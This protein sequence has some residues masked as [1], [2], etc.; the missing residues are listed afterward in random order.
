MMVQCFKLLI[1]IAILEGVSAKGSLIDSKSNNPLRPVLK[2]RGVGGPGGTPF[3]DLMDNDL[4]VDIKGVHSIALT[5]TDQ[6]VE[7]IQVTYLLSNG[8]YYQA[9]RH[10]GNS[11]SNPSVNIK[12]ASGEHV[13]EIKGKGGDNLV[14]Q[15]LFTVVKPEDRLV[16]EYGPY[17]ASGDQEFSLKGYVVGVYGSSGDFLDNVGVYQLA[18]FNKSNMFGIV[19]SDYYVLHFDEPPDTN[20]ILPIVK[21]TKLFIKHGINVVY[22]IQ[23]QYQLLGGAKRLGKK[24]G[25]LDKGQL[26]VINFD[27]DEEILGVVGS[28]TFA[29][30]CHLTF[31]SRKADQ[32][33]MHYG[34]F[35]SPCQTFHYAAYGNI[36]GFFGVYGTR[37]TSDYLYGLGVYYTS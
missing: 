25:V 10:G 12:L 5:Y 29:Y 36:M 9:P 26:T 7:S 20:F 16:K 23:A 32:S 27:S 31:I 28:S 21:V 3:D 14:D 17:G 18:P 34:P 37:T 4:S 22:S 2:S 13:E 19:N 30:L 35:G 1:A 15:L 8:S 24:N 33:I 11:S 6:S